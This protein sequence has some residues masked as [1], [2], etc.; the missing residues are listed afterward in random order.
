[1]GRR[2][3]K[4]LHLPPRMRERHG[5]YF[6]DDKRA[7]A[8]RGWVNL[9]RDYGIALM[10]WAELEGHPREMPRTIAHAIGHYIETQGK[11]LAPETLAGYQRSAARLIKVFGTVLLGDLPPSDVYRFLR[12]EGN[13]QANRDIALLSVVFKWARAWGWHTGENPC[14]KVPRNKEQPRRRY[15]TDAELDKLLAAAENIIIRCVIELAYL[16][17]QRQADV[18]K[19]QMTDISDSGIYLEQGKTGKRQLFSWTDSMRR[20]VDD[21]KRA[22]RRFGR[23][24][25]FETTDG[26]P[27]TGSGFRS[28]WRRV[29]LAA[30]LPDIQFRDLR[31]KTGSDDPEGAQHR[32]GHQ[33]GRVTKRHYIRTPDKVKPIR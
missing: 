11:E 14:L 19:I 12:S 10:K 31:G 21:A 1:M 27:Y 23:K 5:T 7:G 28:M 25:L 29:K 33:D 9:G 18:L 26:S 13:V 2:R 15:V 4:G 22:R 24:F 6:Y 8:A 20:V 32:L 16:I 3:T 17:G 30:G